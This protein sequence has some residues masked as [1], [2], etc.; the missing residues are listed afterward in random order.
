MSYRKPSPE[1]IEDARFAFIEANERARRAEAAFDEARRTHRAVWAP[2]IFAAFAGIGVSLVVVVAAGETIRACNAAP[3]DPCVETYHPP[4]YE[5]EVRCDPRA[6][7]ET[8]DVGI[9]CR[10]GRDGGAP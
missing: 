6:T 2:R 3:P 7:I 5:Y 1:T 9:V 4:A 10:C 8:R